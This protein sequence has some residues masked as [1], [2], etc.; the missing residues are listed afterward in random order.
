MESV[1][2]SF[3]I[4]CYNVA[5]T[6]CRC[7]DSVFALN[8]PET[9]FEVIAID[10]ASS[11]DTLS[12][13]RNYST[14]HK[15]LIVIRHLVNRNLGA[16]RN[17]GLAACKGK[18][19]A[20]V[21]SDDEAC[22]GI[23]NAL[24]LMEKL[25][26]DLVAMRL[27]KVSEEGVI[28]SDLAI[29][30]L[31]GKVFSGLQFQ[32]EHPFWNVAVWSYIFKQSLLNRVHYPFAEGVFY[33]DVDYVCNHF[34][35]ANRMS[36]SDKCGYRFYNNSKSITHTFS[37]KHCFGYA[38]LGI[39]MLTLY[40]RLE[41]KSSSFANSILEGGSYNLMQ[42]FRRLTKLESTSEIRGFYNLLDSKVDRNKI[43]IYREPTYCWT[44]WTRL[45]VKHRSV[46]VLLAGII[47]SFLQFARRIK[48]AFS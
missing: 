26:L 23:I 7:L 28:I 34:L 46:M 21:D 35:K 27:E 48:V 18:Y 6:L 22:D 29:P 5:N 47:V 15:N 11:D 41:D 2:I 8:I 42:A 20:F 9:D 31:S 17:T 43:H 45:G 24:N 36:F 19:V 37:H 38:Y 25:E 16:A 4:P 39:R 14:R 10:D 44:S 1:L 33:E 40:E 3:I 13:L 32:S 12:I 30:E